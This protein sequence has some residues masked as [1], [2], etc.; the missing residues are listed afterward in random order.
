MEYPLLPSVDIQR[1]VRCGWE[2]QSP[3]QPQGPIVCNAAMAPRR[4]YEHGLISE[5]RLHRFQDPVGLFE[6]WIES[7][8][9]GTRGS[10][11]QVSTKGGGRDTFQGLFFNYTQGWRRSLTNLFPATGIGSVTASTSILYPPSLL[12]LAYFPWF[13]SLGSG[14]PQN[15]D[16]IWQVLQLRWAWA[17]RHRRKEGGVRKVRDAKM[18]WG[19]WGA[20]AQVGRLGRRDGK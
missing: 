11:F 17:I 19:T 3:V 14:W 2:V 7:Y 4:G 20:C 13:L 8:Q 10:Q 6:G 16:W 9:R 15:P 18:T 12:F 5:S 1:S